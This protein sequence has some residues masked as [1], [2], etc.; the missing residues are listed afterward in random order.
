[1]LGIDPG[2]RSTGYGVIELRGQHALHLASGCI[3]GVGAD[4]A[5]RLRAIFDGVS[6]VLAAHR[7]QQMAVE[8]VF[9]YRNADSALKLGQARGAA[10]VAGALHGVPVFEYSPAQVKQAIV[11]RGAAQKQQ[12]Q[13]MIKMLL[14]L[15]EL[16]PTD[17]ADALAVALCHGH[18][19][20]G[21][22]Q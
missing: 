11:G 19:R 14:G 2:S 22:R 5:G 12:V 9:M 18:T 3:P 8:R 17:A 20:Q 21:L 1:M 6:A 4:L 13:H 16:P 15:E 7:P 10:L